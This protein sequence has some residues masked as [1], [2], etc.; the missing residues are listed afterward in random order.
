M[1]CFFNSFNNCPNQNIRYIRGPMGPTGATGA[2]GPIGPQ[3]PQGP[4]G[5]QGPIG[6][7]STNNSV[8]AG[9]NTTQTVTA[10][11]VIPIGLIASSPNTNMTVSANAVNITE[12]GT[13]L[14]SY[15]VNGS[16]GSDDLILSLYQNG[17]QIPGE[18]INMQNTADANSSGAKTILL[19][20]T[21]P[22]TLSIFNS[23]QQTATINS[24]TLTV[25][26]VA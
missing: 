10:G 19:N 12:S 13:Y 25:V 15:A 6:V 7:V 17:T 22:A 1:C 5:A 9:T 3:G 8:Y 16:V 11:S 4:Q 21:A 20:V 18:T 2:R 23:S 14:V 26:K 24:G